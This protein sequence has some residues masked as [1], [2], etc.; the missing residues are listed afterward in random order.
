MSAAQQLRDDF[1]D[2]T[3]LSQMRWRGQKPAMP[4]ILTDRRDLPRV[5][6]DLGAMVIWCDSVEE[7]PVKLLTGL[8]VI[9]FFQRCATTESLRQACVAKGARLASLEA[10]CPCGSR[11]T[12]IFEECGA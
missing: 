9:C 12:E 2:W 6:C 1:L 5:L 10:W 3:L 7:A 8:N 11:V 4:V